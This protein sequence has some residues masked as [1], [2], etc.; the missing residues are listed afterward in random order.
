M[1]GAIM[2]T[3]HFVSTE[4]NIFP[5][6]YCYNFFLEHIYTGIYRPQLQIYMKRP[7]H[8]MT[9]LILKIINTE[10]QNA[11]VVPQV[12]IRKRRDG[13]QIFQTEE[14]LKFLCS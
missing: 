4:S 5:H 1:H 6:T 12:L 10:I 7:L 14:F 2:K 11:Q 8:K 3:K 13:A 9:K